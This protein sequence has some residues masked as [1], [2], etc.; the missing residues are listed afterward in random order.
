[1]PSRTKCILLVS[2]MVLDVQVERLTSQLQPK[3]ST[4]PTRLLD[5]PFHF[6]PVAAHLAAPCPT[7]RPNQTAH[8]THEFDPTLVLGS[9]PITSALHL[10]LVADRQTAHHVAAGAISSKLYRALRLN[11]ARCHHRRRLLV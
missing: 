7:T 5:R 4:P 10:D 2:V 8:P 3:L 11:A 1:M 9:S 6:L